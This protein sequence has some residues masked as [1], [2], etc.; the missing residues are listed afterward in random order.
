VI[1]DYLTADITTDIAEETNG[2][3]DHMIFDIASQNTQV[4]YEKRITAR[5]APEEEMI[6]EIAIE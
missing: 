2:D 5:P 3:R 1:T 4:R 6:H